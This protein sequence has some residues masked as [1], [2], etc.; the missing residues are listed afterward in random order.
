MNLAKHRNVQFCKLDKLTQH[1][2]S[3]NYERH[4]QVMVKGE[5]KFFEVVK[6]KKSI[7][8]KVPIATAFFILG[9]AKLT[10]LEF[11]SDMLVC[12]DPRSYRLLY[13]GK[14]NF[15]RINKN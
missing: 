8:D 15:V 1:I 11:I 9:N 12:I 5:P 3:N 2:R 7:T 4:V 6:T 10:V 13:M 14:E